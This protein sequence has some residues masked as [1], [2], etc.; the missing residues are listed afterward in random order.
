MLSSD[1]FCP[2]MLNREFKDVALPRELEAVTKRV[3]LNVILL[4]PREVIA[5]ILVCAVAPNLR[6]ICVSTLENDRMRE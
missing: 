3:P 6:L 2:K 5:D 1:R 4:P